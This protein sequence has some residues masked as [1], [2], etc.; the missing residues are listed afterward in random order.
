MTTGGSC[1]AGRFVASGLHKQ[2]ALLDGGGVEMTVERLGWTERPRGAQNSFRTALPRN[3]DVQIEQAAR[4][5]KVFHGGDGL[6]AVGRSEKDQAL[7]QRTA[8]AQGSFDEQTAGAQGAFQASG[9]EHE[10]AGAVN[11]Q[12]S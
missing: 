7:G 11:V 1:F 9:K 4:D 2:D 5:K 12:H 3:L 8:A 10:L 6:V